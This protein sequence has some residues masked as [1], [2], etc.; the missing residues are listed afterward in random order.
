MMTDEKSDGQCPMCGALKVHGAG[1][2][3]VCGKG[4]YSPLAD[5]RL[6]EILTARKQ[7]NE[8]EAVSV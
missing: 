8:Q 2:V 4:R 3:C 6:V 7:A 5:G 1:E